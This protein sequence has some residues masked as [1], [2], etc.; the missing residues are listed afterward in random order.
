MIDFIAVFNTLQERE[1]EY[2]CISGAVIPQMIHDTV[3]VKMGYIGHRL[4][5]PVQG[6]SHSPPS[7]AQK[8]TAGFI[9]LTLF[10]IVSVQ[11]HRPPELCCDPFCHQAA[12]WYRKLTRL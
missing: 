8:F 4:G 3:D 6:V 5:Y 12:L 1:S 2:I 11:C 7:P 9:L 10:A